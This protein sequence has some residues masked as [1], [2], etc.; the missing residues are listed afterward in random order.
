[1]KKNK[2]EETIE[3]LLRKTQE[4]LDGDDACTWSQAVAN[5]AHATHFDKEVKN[6]DPD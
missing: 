2:Y 6:E 3:H 1:M 4:A 5:I